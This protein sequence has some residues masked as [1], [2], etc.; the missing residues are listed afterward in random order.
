MTRARRC[1]A[2]VLFFAE[3]LGLAGTGRTAASALP[4]DSFLLSPPRVPHLK[5]AMSRMF[6]V[7]FEGEGNE[8]SAPS[9]KGKYP[10]DAD[11]CG[12]LLARIDRLLVRAKLDPVLGPPIIMLRNEGEAAYHA[13]R[14]A[15]CRERLREAARLLGMQVD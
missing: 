10:S 7:R 14:I 12:A 13:G 5:P 6:T 11:D 4:D 15:E 8:V 3:A 2:C 1:F 9:E